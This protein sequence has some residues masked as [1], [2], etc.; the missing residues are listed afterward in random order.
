M[1]VYCE[2]A[3]A[4][5]NQPWNHQRPLKHL[6]IILNPVANARKGKKLFF[7]YAQPILSCAGIKLSLIETEHEGI[8]P[9][10]IFYFI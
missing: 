1:R 2:E 8:L 10:F 3:A 5:G 9:T 4:I 7:N 6:T